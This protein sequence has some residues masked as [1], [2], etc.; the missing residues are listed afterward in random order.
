[1][2][3]FKSVELL[4]K[5]LNEASMEVKTSIFNIEMDMEGP[6]FEELYFKKNE[7]SFSIELS[8]N[9]ASILTYSSNSLDLSIYEC[10]KQIDYSLAA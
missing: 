4:R 6:S 8:Y 7:A 9:A 3:T 1:M 10:N 2:E 5:V